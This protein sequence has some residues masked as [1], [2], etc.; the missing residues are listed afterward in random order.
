MCYVLSKDTSIQDK[1][2]QKGIEEE[3]FSLRT[4]EAT[5]ENRACL[6]KSALSSVSFSLVQNMNAR[7]MT[8]PT[9]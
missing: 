6:L 1:T 8:E 2:G 9:R 5:G 3:M 7:K 4:G